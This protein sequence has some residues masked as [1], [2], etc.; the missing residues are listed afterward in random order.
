VCSSDLE[1]AAAFNGLIGAMA[2][3]NGLDQKTMQ[4]IYIGIMACGKR[5]PQTQQHLYFLDELCKEDKHDCFS[6]KA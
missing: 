2:L 5:L 3:Q 6:I 1:A 4:L